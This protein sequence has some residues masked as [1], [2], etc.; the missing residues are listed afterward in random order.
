MVVPHTFDRHLNF[1][2]HLHILVTAGG[3][4]IGKNAW[5]RNLRI[6]KENLADV[7][8]DAVSEYLRLALKQGKLRSSLNPLDM[9]ELLVQQSQRKWVIRIKNFGNKKHFLKYAA[10]YVRHP[11]IA[12][13]RFVEIGP[14]EIVFRTQDHRLKKEVLTRHTPRKF[15]ELLALHVRDR[16]RH[17]MWY[18]GLFAPGEKARSLGAILAVLGQER[19]PRPK[20]LSWSLSIKREFGTDPLLDSTGT[21]MRLVGRRPPMPF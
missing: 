15:I 19:R 12:Q 9:N 8:R 11:P 21:R 6:D 5:A 3:L 16:Y 17:S 14:E 1:V 4:R 10:R 2:P 18:F 13:Y 7:W 20:R